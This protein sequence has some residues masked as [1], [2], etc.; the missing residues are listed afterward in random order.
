MR[1]A[2]TGSVVIDILRAAERRTEPPTTF[3]LD[4]VALAEAGGVCV[5]V[6][7]SASEWA[8]T[9]CGGGGVILPDRPIVSM[10][11]DMT[12]ES[13]HVLPDGYAPSAEELAEWTFVTPNLAI[14]DRW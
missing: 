6:A 9:A 13:A 14:S 1:S 5:V 11:V 12:G 3:D 2:P 10:Y 8:G 4:W 7:A